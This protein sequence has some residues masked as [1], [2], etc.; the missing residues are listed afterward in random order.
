MHS[1]PKVTEVVAHLKKAA[2]SWHGLMPPCKL[3]EKAACVSES[4]MSSSM[5]YGTLKIP[6]RASHCL[7]NNDAGQIFER[8]TVPESLTDS[9]ATTEPFSYPGSPS[10]TFTEPPQE[11]PPE[12]VVKPPRGQSP[13]RWGTMTRRPQEPLDDLREFQHM[14]LNHRPPPSVVPPPKRKPFQSFKAK[15]REFFSRLLPTHDH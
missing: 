6:S 5:R 4:P 3:A 9:R 7:L 13:N 8:S 2:S 12:T 1:R 10:T 15:V 11:E 14:A